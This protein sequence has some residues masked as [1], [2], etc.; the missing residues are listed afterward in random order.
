MT[1]SDDTQLKRTR[2]TVQ[3]PPLLSEANV[4]IFGTSSTLMHIV[5]RSRLVQCGRVHAEAASEL[6]DWARIVRRRQYGTPLEVKVDFPSASF[7]RPWKTVFNIHRNDYR[8]VVDIRY[9]LG[10]VYVRHIVTHREYD[11]LIDKGLL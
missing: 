1:P 6:R 10:R 11:R 3:L 2:P 9:D 8:L 7:I 4:P 5:T